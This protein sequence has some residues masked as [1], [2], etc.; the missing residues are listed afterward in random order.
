ML[1]L[2]GDEKF[3]IVRPAGTAGKEFEIVGNAY[4]RNKSRAEL[5]SRGSGLRR[6]LLN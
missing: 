1:A 2:L 5:V 3:L 4:V 6:V